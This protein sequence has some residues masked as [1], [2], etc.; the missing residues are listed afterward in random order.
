[1]TN[2]LDSI[3]KTVKDVV[4]VTGGKHYLGGFEDFAKMKQSNFDVPFRESLPRLPGL[5]FYY[6]QEDVL[7]DRSKKNGFNWYVI[8]PAEIIGFAPF[9]QMNI[10][11]TL[12]VY[13]TIC[14]HLNLPFLF[15]GGIASIDNFR[16][17][18]DTDLIASQIVWAINEPKAANQAM[19]CVNGDVFSW[20][21][22][23]KNIGDYFG[24]RTEEPREPIDLEKLMADKGPVW[25]EIVKKHNLQ[26]FKLNELTSW[27]FV[28]AV[29]NLKVSFFASTTKVRKLGFKE[30]QDTG[31]S[32]AK[33]FDYLKKNKYIP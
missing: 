3:N 12:A 19:N 13:A 5:N 4:L 6:N 21:Q 2:I 23:W 25:D 15:P 22:M 9:N 16:D 24:L 17:A 28:S 27:W 32:Y 20:R 10:G 26:P 1:M 31:E 8:R 7:F 30:Y 14:K 33:L 18:S 29:T 11:T